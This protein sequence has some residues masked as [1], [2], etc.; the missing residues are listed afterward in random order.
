M[1]HVLIWLV[2][3]LSATFALAQA[4]EPKSVGPADTLALAQKAERYYMARDWDDAIRLYRQ[5]VELNPT[6]GM[7]QYRLGES[8]L[9][10]K[11]YA[12]AVEPLQQAIELGAFQHG[13]VKWVH[14]GEAAYL[15]AAAYAGQGEKQKAIEAARLSLKQGLRSIRKFQDKRFEPI[16]TD[17]EFRELAWLDMD[18]V[19][20]LSR[21]QRFRRDLV[22]AVHEL[23]R[24]H[25]APFRAHTEAEIDSLVAG[26]DAEIPQLT[27]DQIYVR[28]LA[29]ISAFGDCHTRWLRET[30]LLPVTLFAYPEGLHVLGASRQHADLVGA[31][32]LEIGGHPIDEVLALGISLAPVENRMTARWE[33]AGLLRS[34]VVLRGLGLAPADGPVKLKVE[35]AKGTV[36]EV[37]LAAPEKRLAR[38]DFVFAVPGCTTE[39]PRCL[40]NRHEMFWHEILPDGKTIYCQLNGIGHGK[41]LFHRYFEKLFAEIDSA[42]VERLVLDLRW[43]GGGNTF[44]NAPLIEGILRSDKFRKPGN[45]FVIVGRNTFSA[46]INTTV[47]LERRTSAILVGEPPSSP[48]NFVG[49][50]VEVV[51]PASRWPLSISDLWWQTSYPMDYRQMISPQIYA[52]PTAAALRAHRDP[53]LEAIEAYITANPVKP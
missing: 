7:Y 32:V 4:P 6:S 51:L 34:L 42:G 38:E 50:S 40:R 2:F 33:A 35:D 19:E 3:V 52:P 12:A 25:Y 31:R 53:A 21:D 28:M 16:A 48:P 20:G 45:L 30:P 26:L 43:N 49:E 27:D 24:L 17:P 29:V 8:L 41:Q 44:L 13:P 47:D 22:F 10:D 37:T 14:R 39:L 23:K 46:A 15:L 11:Q 18:N 5:L 9:G 1:N 36:R